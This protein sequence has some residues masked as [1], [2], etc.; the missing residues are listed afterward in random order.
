MRNK[1]YYNEA[2]ELITNKKCQKCLKIKDLDDFT[3]SRN[4]KFGKHNW[5]SE[6]LKAYNKEIYNRDREERIRDVGIWN[7]RNKNKVKVYSENYR[8]K[9]KPER[10]KR[11]KGPVIP[12]IGDINTPFIPDF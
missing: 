8:D 3:N 6:C 2:D 5:C 9:V 1:S 10:Q 7:L 12:D 4:G 11:K